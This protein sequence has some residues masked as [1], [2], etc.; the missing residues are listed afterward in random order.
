MREG[1][2]GGLELCSAL[3]WIVGLWCCGDVVLWCCSCVVLVVDLPQTRY[4]ENITNG[5]GK[6]R[7]QD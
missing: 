6:N 1:M 4:S 3:L 2:F 7:I 5:G